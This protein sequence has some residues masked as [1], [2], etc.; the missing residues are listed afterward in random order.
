MDCQNI[1][2]SP[3]KSQERFRRA[4]LIFPSQ[5]LNRVLFFAL[6]LLGARMNEMASLVDMPEE[7]V[8][9]I[10]SRIMKDGVPAFLDRRKS[11]K[12][13]GL[14]SSPTKEPQASALIEDNYCVIT[15]EDKEHQLKI[16]LKHRV[17]LKSVLL[18]LLQ[19]NLLT[20]QTVS[21]IVGISATHCRTLS[22][23]LMNDG[24]NEVLIDKR[25]GQKLDFRI[26]PSVKAALIEHFAARAVTG[27]S[28]ASHVLAEIIN[29]KEKTAISA[30]TIRWHMNKL[31]LMTIKKTLP[32][33]VDTLKKTSEPTV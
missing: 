6:Y 4:L 15:F 11:T 9:T 13:S 17:H 12:T 32:E 31:G 7:S 10:I 30:R 16:P 24:V 2:F 1:I 20:S 26:V 14:Q 18:S 19:A 22:T 33:L 3:N 25:K 27:H 21:S 29:D 28:T 8:K 5:V 23:K